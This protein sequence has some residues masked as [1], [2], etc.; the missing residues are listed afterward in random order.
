LNA[1]SPPPSP[2]ILSMAS[3]PST[4]FDNIG[5]DPS[6]REIAASPFAHL[7]AAIWTSS[8]S[9]ESSSEARSQRSETPSPSPEPYDGH[10]NYAC[11]KE[12]HPTMNGKWT[13]HRFP[14]DYSPIEL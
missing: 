7:D 12:F 8:S 6:D 9:S 1:S 13:G 14:L 10:A 4:P 11:T 3:S 2:H 5:Q